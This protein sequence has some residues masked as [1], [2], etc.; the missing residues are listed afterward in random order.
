[1]ST[2]IVQF[3]GIT[4]LCRLYKYFDIFIELK[5]ILKKIANY[6]VTSTSNAIFIIGGYY[7]FDLDD[8]AKFQDAQWTRFGTLNTARRYHGSINL[9]EQMMIIGGLTNNK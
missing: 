9:G 6:A 4:I 5:D 8:V 3:A 1:M 7:G 2:L